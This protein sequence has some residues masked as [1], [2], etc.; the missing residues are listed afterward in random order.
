VLLDFKF[1]LVGHH[2][3]IESACL[4]GLLDTEY[5]TQGEQEIGNW[6]RLAQTDSV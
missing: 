5:G 2:V 1:E 3:I 6:V 4:L